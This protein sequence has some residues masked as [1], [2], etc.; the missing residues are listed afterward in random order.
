MQSILIGK[1]SNV[2]GI[3]GEVKVYP[4]TDDIDTFSKRK[5]FYI[6]SD[7]SIKYKVIRCRI[8]KD[9][10]IMKL[11][12]IDSVDDALELKGKDLYIDKSSLQSLDSD[13][14]YVDDIIGM[15]VICQGDT[16][17][18]ITYIFNT[19]A[20]DV[21]EVESIDGKKV[22]LPAI[23]QVVKKVDLSEKKMYVEIMEGLM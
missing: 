11:D 14:Y 15:Q 9:M 5:E 21:Y 16:I 3:K 23:H 12:G 19:G 17:G 4:Y 20:N 22:Y 8:Q 7:L 18:Y 13:T 1:I 6:D 2:H 10:L